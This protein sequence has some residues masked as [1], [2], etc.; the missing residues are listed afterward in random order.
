MECF[1]KCFQQPPPQDD[2]E[3]IQPIHVANKRH[4]APVEESTRGRKTRA[5]VSVK[6]VEALKQGGASIRWT[7][8]VLNLHEV[9][10]DDLNHEKVSPWNH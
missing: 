2:G 7:N 9:D 5:S 1:R 4:V 8:M 6:G 3:W 10:M